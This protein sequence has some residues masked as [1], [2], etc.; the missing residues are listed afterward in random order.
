MTL[1]SDFID[2]CEADLADSENATWSA[3]DVEQ[4]S[5]DAIADYSE[6]FPRTLTAQIETDDDDRTYDLPNDFLKPILVEHPIDNDPPTY[7][8]PRLPQHPQFWAEDGFYCIVSRDDD[9]DVNEIW[10]STKPADDDEINITYKAHH[11]NSIATNVAITIPDEHAHILR[12]YV[13]WRATLQLKFTEEAAPTSSSSLLMS[14]LAQSADRLQR[15]YT[16]SLAKALFEAQRTGIVSWA[17][18]VPETSRIY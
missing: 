10:I 17:G 4:W 11:D 15:Q 18:Q 6:H 16:N 14:Q 5:R 3:T 7:L 13:V 2:L 1:L 12:N 9:T 8:Q